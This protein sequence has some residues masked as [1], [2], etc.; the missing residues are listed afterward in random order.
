MYRIYGKRC[1][2]LLCS[3]LLLL[4]LAPVMAIIAACVFIALGSP[5]LFRQ[6]RPGLHGKLYMLFKFRTMKDVRDP[7]GNPLPDHDRLTR[8]GRFLRSTSLDELPELL[9]VLAGQMSLVGPRPLL[10]HYLGLYNEEQLRRH[11]VLPG[12]TGWAQVNGRNAI[13]W[14][15]RFKLDVWYVD[16]LSFRLDV[17]ILLMTVSRVLRRQ[18]INAEGEA[19]MPEFRGNNPEKMTVRTNKSLYIYGAS[20]HA[21]VIVDIA[22]C[23]GGWTI[24]GILDDNPESELFLGYQVLNARENLSRLDPHRDNIV[25]A[26]GANLARSQLGALIAGRG[27]I[28]PAL[29]HPTAVIARNVTVGAG[30]VIMAG[31]VINPSTAIG[32]LCILNTACTVDH[33]CVI[34][35]A[36]HIS[37]G[38]HLAGGVIVGDESWI[39]IGAS[40]IQQCKIGSR[41]MIG[42]GAVVI[43]DVADDVTVVGVPA[44]SVAPRVT[45]FRSTARQA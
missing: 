23:M 42:A 18:G 13:L 35:Q 40:I 22:E 45:A 5:V 16:N 44:R 24:C 34:G 17:R 31:V 28:L 43:N 36:V 8:L 27:F 26:I 21:K 37:P 38:A 4:S 1:F 41:S 3:A 9:N 14:Q 12:V 32:G 30:T 10:M 19:S 29:I 2:D 39:G 25:I 20:G 6:Q 7:N 33:D 11:N 15:E